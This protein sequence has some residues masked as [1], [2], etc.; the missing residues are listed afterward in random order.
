MKSS[1]ENDLKIEQYLNNKKISA[2]LLTQVI[3]FIILVFLIIMALFNPVFKLIYDKVLV[4][5]LL[6]MAFNNKKIYKRK[7]LTELLILTS[8]FMLFL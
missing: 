8:I 5:T 3:C 7:Y 4:L 2:Y 1:L 6:V